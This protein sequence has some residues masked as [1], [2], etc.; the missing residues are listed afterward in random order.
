MT[1]GVDLLNDFTRAVF[2][3]FKAHL[4]ASIKCENGSSGQ[5]LEA[6]MG[7]LLGELSWGLVTPT[8]PFWDS[9]LKLPYDWS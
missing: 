8:F 6:K 2:N 3:A 4:K 7:L 5:E 9:G 1:L